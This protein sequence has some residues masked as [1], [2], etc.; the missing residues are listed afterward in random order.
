MYVGMSTRMLE[1]KLEYP[2]LHTWGVSIHQRVYYWSTYQDS[3]VVDWTGCRYY[4]EKA[5]EL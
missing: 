2:W 1:N 4:R 3:I 5:G